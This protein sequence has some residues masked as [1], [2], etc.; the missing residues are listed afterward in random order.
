MNWGIMEYADHLWR[1]SRSDTGMF[2]G[3]SNW[4]GPIWMLVNA[5]LIRALLQYY[6]YYGDNFKIE[7]PTGLGTLMNYE[8]R[9]RRQQ[10]QLLRKRAAKLGLQVA[11]IHT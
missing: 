7:C 10:I 1:M 4:R 6:L 5:I 8:E 9:F 3:N 11:E 2:G